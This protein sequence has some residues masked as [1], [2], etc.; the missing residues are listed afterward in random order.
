MKTIKLLE[1]FS[2]L[3]GIAAHEKNVRVAL[4]KY[5]KPLCDEIIYDGLGGLFAL[6][7]SKNP[8]A[9]KV[10]VAAHMDEVGFIVSHILSNGLLKIHPIGGIDPLSIIASRV[11]IYPQDQLDKVVYGVVSSVPPH[12]LKNKSNQ[13][14]TTFNELFIDIGASSAD[15]VKKALIRPGDMVVIH[16]EFI[17]T[18]NQDRVIGKA[19]DNRY[20]CVLGIELLNALAKTELPFDLYIGANVQEEVGLRGAS[21]S[22]NLIN[23]DLAIVLDASPAND[24][25]NDPN[26]F[27]H[28]GQGGLI[29]IVDANM[30][31]HQ[32]FLN[33][34]LALYEK[35][36]LPYQYYVSLGGTDAGAIHKSNHGIPTLTACIPAR[37]IHTSQSLIDLNDYNSVKLMLIELLKTMDNKVLKLIKEH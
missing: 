9:F 3:P 37:Y 23:P 26:A 31:P 5:Y 28:L 12:L 19:F 27:G 15:Q 10:L 17:K 30:V 2:N 36:N 13:Q 24:L 7:K 18:I 32:N 16:H 20:G 34:A 25:S 8:N 21:A 33:Y 11:A 29:R 4:E 1:E 6:K 35:L 22:T 14:P